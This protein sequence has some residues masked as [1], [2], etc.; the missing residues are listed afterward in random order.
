ME[1]RIIDPQK[2]L[3][4]IGAVILIVGLAGSVLIYITAENNSESVLGYETAG[5]Y[6][7]PILPEDSKK[8]IH[9]MEL[10][11]GKANVLANEFMSWFTGLWHGRSLAFTVGFITLFVSSGIFLVANHLPF[12]TNSDPRD[13]HNRAGSD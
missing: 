13:E 4:L 2:R 1:W 11:G 5:G 6:V 12:D 3:Y 9:D 8:Y 7:Y 10:Y